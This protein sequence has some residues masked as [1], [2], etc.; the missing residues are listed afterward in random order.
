MRSINQVAHHYP[1]LKIAI[2]LI[3]GMVAAV[4]AGYYGTPAV[5]FYALV[6]ALLLAF[7]LYR[8]AVGQSIMLLLLSF[9]LGGY[10]LS[11]AERDM[12]VV[13]P[14]TPL[15]YQAIVTSQPVRHGKVIQCDFMVV[16]QQVNTKPLQGEAAPKPL[17]VRASILCDTLTKRFEHL[18][19]GDG[20]AYYAL[21]TPLRQDEYC[22]ADY[23]RWLHAQGYQATTFVYWSDWQK[24]AVPLN[25][26]S[27]VERT[28]L[29]FLQLRNHL[30]SRFSSLGME[31]GSLS[32]LLAM[33][34]GDK[35]QVTKSLRNDYSISGSSHILAI[36]GLHLTILFS[37]LFFFFRRWRRR[38]LF[39]LLSM[40]VVWGYVVLVGMPSSAV[41]AAVMLTVC[42]V[43]MLL[44]RGT[45]SLNTLSFAAIL[46]LVVR[47]LNLFDIGFQLSFA[48]VFA[49]LIWMPLFDSFVRWSSSAWWS[50][51]LRALYGL[52]AVSL[53]AQLGTAPLVAYYFGR[54]SC[55]FMLTN[56]V[57]IPLAYLLLFLMMLVLFTLPVPFLQSVLLSAAAFLASLLNSAMHAIAQLPGASIEHLHP[58]VLQVL[59]LYLLLLI[60]YFISLT[61]S[62]KVSIL[63]FF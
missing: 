44:N 63:N 23:L 46:M 38:R 34:L 52:L 39:L 3:L 15:E 42:T 51:S 7:A 22:S 40:L 10:L 31:E 61:F 45:V 55:Y 37:F 49:I 29:V 41:R 27:L 54:F 33:F 14:N 57:A 59:L 26:L 1:L 58:S 25:T 16:S 62:R 12:Q 24:A 6:V 47:P 56:L 13:L 28:R 32:V 48:A 17:K 4:Q 19:V 35:S 50:R 9:L 21:L 43:F 11:R 18:H 2:M 60:F 8:W 20:I 36:S 5:W 30:S 53:A